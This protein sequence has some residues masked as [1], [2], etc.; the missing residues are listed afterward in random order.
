MRMTVFL[1][2]VF[3]ISCAGQEHPSPCDVIMTDY[4]DASSITI[5]TS[6]NGEF[7]VRVEALNKGKSSGLSAIIF[8]WNGNAYVR[9]TMFDLLG[10]YPNEVLVSNLG[11][12]ATIGKRNAR[13]NVDEINVYSIKSGLIQTIVSPGFEYPDKSENCVLKKPWICWR[14]PISITDEN[15]NLLDLNGNEVNIDLESGEYTKSRSV[16]ACEDFR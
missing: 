8:K 1:I 3:S 13:T 11:N 12:M 2:L 9:E 14:Y 4:R 6:S 10:G 16:D 5:S 15:L 7:L